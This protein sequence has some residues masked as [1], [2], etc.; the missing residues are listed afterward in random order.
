MYVYIQFPLSVIIIYY[1]SSAIIYHTAAQDSYIYIYM[2]EL[3]REEGRRR[4]S[5]RERRHAK[6]HI[7]NF[8][9]LLCSWWKEIYMDYVITLLV[10]Y[11]YRRGMR[12]QAI[13]VTSQLI[14]IVADP[15]MIK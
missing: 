2:C 11:S 7:E 12:C 14:I 8:S 10:E 5:G 4:G 1:F 13:E 15:G 6:F 9:S 3:K